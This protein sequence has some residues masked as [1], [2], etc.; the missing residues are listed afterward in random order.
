VA[1]WLKAAV[2]KTVIRQRI[3]SSNLCS[4]ANF[5]AED[6]P[7]E[8]Y[9]I[10]ILVPNGDPEGVR[11]IDRMNWTGLGFVFPREEWPSVQGRQI[12]SGPGV[13]ILVGPSEI[14]EN[15][16]RLYIGEADNISRRI[17]DH[18]RDREFWS[19]GIAFVSSNQG[20]NKAHV[21]WLEHS[22][23]E[24]AR[25]AKRSE[26]DNGN[27][28]QRPALHEVDETDAKA[29]LK[30]VLQILP[31]VGLQAFREPRIVS[32]PS[33]KLSE[34]SKIISTTE[35]DTI[36]V[37]A[38]QDGFERVFLGQNCWFAIRISGGMINKIKYIA[39]YVTAPASR[40]THV[41]PVER[42]EL[43]GEE[44]KYKVIF[45]EPAKE[46]EQAILK[47]DAKAGVQGP[48]YTSYSRLMSAKQLKDLQQK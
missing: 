6:H 45:S 43:Y 13:Y 22:L 20:L 48:I 27:I 18:F 36:V 35:C 1:E 30:E 12:L 8:G 47:G 25:S 9:T 39:A 7:M 5:A 37:P 3:Q 28:P 2:S 38:Y 11:M 23:Y 10:R 21:K 29:F 40:I 44:G 33:A 24:Q 15:I 4:S 19:W 17:G 14:D 31:L 26:L 42:I 34:P 46:L 16:P 32:S 41:A